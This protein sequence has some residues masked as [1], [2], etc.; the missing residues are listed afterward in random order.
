MSFFDVFLLRRPPLSTRI[1][2]LYPSTPLFRSRFAQ[3]INATSVFLLIELFALADFD[4]AGRTTAL[5]PVVCPVDQRRIARGRTLAATVDLV[6][7]LLARNA[8]RTGDRIETMLV[9]IQSRALEPH[10]ETHRAAMAPFR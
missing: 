6:H 4:H 2:T 7:V 3:R 1:D 5:A 8:Q 9:C 10:I